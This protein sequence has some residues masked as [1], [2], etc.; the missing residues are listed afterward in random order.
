M[1]HF[2]PSDRQC[3]S[4][5]SWVGRGL[6]FH[7]NTA[8]IHV[9]PT[10][11]SCVTRHHSYLLTRLFGA[12]IFIIR[13]MGNWG[14]RYV[15]GWHCRPVRLGLS[16]V[17]FHVSSHTCLSAIS[18]Q[19]VD[20]PSTPLPSLAIVTPTH[21]SMVRCPTRVCYN[22]QHTHPRLTVSSSL[23]VYLATVWVA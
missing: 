14:G 10:G 5:S 7:P 8:C 17:L 16:S 11:V 19:S 6:P 21:N 3:R 18:T 4:G 23:T 13:R 2:R 15:T 20:L 9:L 1:A 22:H 12:Y